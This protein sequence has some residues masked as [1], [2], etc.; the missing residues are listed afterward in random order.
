MKIEE[1]SVTL[2]F[3]DNNYFR[4]EECKGY[5]DIQNNFKEMDACWYDE[6]KD[7]LYLI[8][9][10]DWKT[11][12]I[13]EENDSNIP[14]EEII[15]TKTGISKSRVF[16]L[17][18]KSVDSV[19]MILSAMLNTDYST[20]IS[21]CFS[22]KITKDTKIRLISII[23]WEETDISYISNVNTAYKSKFGSYAKLFGIRTFIV[24][25]KE[26]AKTQFDWVE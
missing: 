5:K 17:F 4:F 24:L 2:N 7:E 23:N 22:F 10:K 26:Q 19:C 6:T 20:A 15:D 1:S 3:P 9:L 11:D 18:K 8:E 13:Y 16:T 21:S 12:K 14:I 25:T